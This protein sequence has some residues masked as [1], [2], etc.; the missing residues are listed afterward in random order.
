MNELKSYKNYTPTKKVPVSPSDSISFDDLVYG[1][2]ELK[3][4][5]NNFSNC[6]NISELLLNQFMKK[7]TENEKISN[8]AQPLFRN[9]MVSFTNALSD[10]EIHLGFQKFGH[11]QD[12]SIL[13]EKGLEIELFD[14]L[15]NK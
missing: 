9:I 12:I 8:V 4:L 7:K 14:S 1:K 13:R 3:K 2:K 10:S 11:I 15:F 6:S 5:S